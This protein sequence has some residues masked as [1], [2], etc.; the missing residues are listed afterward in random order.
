[1]QKNYIYQLSEDIEWL[2]IIESGK[3]INSVLVDS[4][5]ISVDTLEDYE[6][7]VAKYSQ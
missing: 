6:Y 4:S 2:K 7:L 1:M 5:E 3:K